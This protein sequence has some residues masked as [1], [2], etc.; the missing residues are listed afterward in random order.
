MGTDYFSQIELVPGGDHV[1]LTFRL[2]QM[3]SIA[4]LLGEPYA[5]LA[6]F[7]DSPSSRFRAQ[8]K[9]LVVMANAL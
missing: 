3:I 2:G 6:S 7:T 4:H 8:R 9:V 5:A 1:P